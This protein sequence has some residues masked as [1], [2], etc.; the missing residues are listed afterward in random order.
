MLES[1]GSTVLTVLIL[2]L[3]AIPLAALYAN[4]QIWRLW[5]QDEKRPRSWVLFA[6]AWA[7]TM[8]NLASVPI[9]W[10]AF[11]RLV[12]A[13]ALDPIIALGVLAVVLV[14]VEFTPIYFWLTIRRRLA[15]AAAN[16]QRSDGKMVVDSADD[17]A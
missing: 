9:A 5:L 11:R 17:G 3:M 14:A 6:M 13:P 4:V 15:A 7:G 2:I 12:D 8:I 1:V 10:L 16:S